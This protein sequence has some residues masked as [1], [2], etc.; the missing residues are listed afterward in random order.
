MLTNGRKINLIKKEIRR[1]KKKE[2]EKTEEIWVIKD[3]IIF[4]KISK[5]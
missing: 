5:S 2:N 3:G 4:P 1:K